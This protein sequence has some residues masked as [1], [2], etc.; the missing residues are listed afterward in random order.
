MN[1]PLATGPLSPSAGD[2]QPVVFTYSKRD[3]EKAVNSATGWTKECYSEFD[4]LLC[5]QWDR[6]V[7]D[8]VFRYSLD[9]VVTRLVPG[10]YGF[11]A[12]RNPKRF[13]HRR[14]PDEVKSICQPFNRE[15]FNFNKVKRS[16]ILL[17]LKREGGVGHWLLV[18]VSP[19][20]YGHVLLVPQPQDCL[21]QIMTQDSIQLCLDVMAM[22]GHSGLIMVANSLLAYAS[23]NHLHYHFMYTAQPLLAAT[24][25]GRPLTRSCFEL[26][27]HPIPGFGFQLDTPTYTCAENIF[28]VVSILI[29]ANIPHNLVMLRG[30]P[31]NQGSS[32]ADC[33]VRALLIPRKPAYG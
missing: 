1:S 6:A 24:V 17:E 22:S 9:E 3:V 27:D 11:I 32:T 25:T 21:P 26:V 33:V 23:V 15:L 13:S 14:K 20:D 19:I 7:A 31:F 8:G 16:E 2:P 5:S 30:V 10:R 29:D 4:T 28:K 18:N 12:Q